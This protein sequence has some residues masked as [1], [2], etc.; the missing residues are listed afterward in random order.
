LSAS[1]GRRLTQLLAKD[2]PTMSLW[3][4][5]DVLAYGDAPLERMLRSLDFKP[6]LTVRYPH[7]IRDAT[8]C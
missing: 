6:V 7:S 8:H 1:Y 3:R 2:I 5:H 4:Q